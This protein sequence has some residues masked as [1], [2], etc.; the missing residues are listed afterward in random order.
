MRCMVS[1]FKISTYLVLGL[2]SGRCF[3]AIVSHWLL[4]SGSHVLCIIA[5]E[6]I[7]S[8]KSLIVVC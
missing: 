1:S 2:V 8:M 7:V 5:H 4:I 6:W 3:V